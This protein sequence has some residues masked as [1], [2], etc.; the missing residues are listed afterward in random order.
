[1]YNL[2]EIS[3]KGKV[4]RQQFNEID[5]VGE[6]EIPE[7]ELESLCSSLWKYLQHTYNKGKFLQTDTVGEF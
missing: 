3:L 1:M 5:F 6:I 2:Q 4:F 7:V